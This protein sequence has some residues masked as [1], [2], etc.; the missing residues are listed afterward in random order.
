MTLLSYASA[1]VRGGWW[2]RLAVVGGGGVCGAGD[3]DGCGGSVYGGLGFC[4]GEAFGGQTRLILS[5]SFLSKLSDHHHG[6][7]SSDQTSRPQ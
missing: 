2:W 1:C 3:A 5:F 4:E 7:I 6:P